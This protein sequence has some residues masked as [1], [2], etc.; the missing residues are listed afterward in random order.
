[1][2]DGIR[3]KFGRS[4][5][6]DPWDADQEL[7]PEQEESNEL[8]TDTAV[9]VAAT[10]TVGRF[11]P[12]D[13]NSQDYYKS[14][15]INAIKNGGKHGDHRIPVPWLRMILAGLEYKH[16]E[17]EMMWYCV[18]AGS[19]AAEPLPEIPSYDDLFPS[20]RDAPG[21]PGPR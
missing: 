16:I 17:P 13:V 3:R 21:A 11:S 12:S 2:I 14:V 8:P 6:K 10:D 5:E 7:R 15:V 1:M 20:E 19:P 18:E 9:L 4:I